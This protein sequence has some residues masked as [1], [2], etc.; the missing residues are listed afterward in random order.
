M[1]SAGCFGCLGRGTRVLVHGKGVCPHRGRFNDTSDKV[2]RLSV[3]LAQ[4]RQQELAVLSELMEAG[5]LTPV[6]DRTY[7]LSEI[8]AAIEYS[9]QGHARGK[10]IVNM[11]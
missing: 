4:I 11:E 10:I 8:P 3:L 2:A 7:P 6:I 5:D 1:S 9:E